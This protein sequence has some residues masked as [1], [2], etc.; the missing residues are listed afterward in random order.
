MLMLPLCLKNE[1]TFIL[2]QFY[3]VCFVIKGLFLLLTILR[4]CLLNSALWRWFQDTLFWSG[5]S[6]VQR[7]ARQIKV[8]WDILKFFSI[9][10]FLKREIMIQSW[11]DNVGTWEKQRYLPRWYSDTGLKGT[12]VNPT[13]HSLKKIASLNESACT[14]ALNEHSIEIRAQSALSK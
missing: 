6:D 5:I 2:F 9:V 7:Y 12:V 13:Y 14:I 11:R 10:A 4:I 8:K 1:N 3:T